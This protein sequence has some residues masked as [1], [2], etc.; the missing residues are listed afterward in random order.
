MRTPEKIVVERLLSMTRLLDR[1]SRSEPSM[2]GIVTQELIQ[3]GDVE[4]RR[5]ELASLRS[6]L[7]ELID[8]LGK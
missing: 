7:G 2:V 3:T 8:E 1:A 4:T 6:F 5:T